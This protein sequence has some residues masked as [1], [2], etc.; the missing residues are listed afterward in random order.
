MSFIDPIATAIAEAL[1]PIIRA[2]LEAALA[3]HNTMQPAHADRGQPN[4]S[5]AE[6]ALELGA[7]ERQVR[8][9]LAAGRLRGSRAVL[10]G[11]SRVRI[12][13]QSV[14]ALLRGAP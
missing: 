7:S 6:A 11:S 1:R 2:E 14:D 13:R 3:A 4:C 9:W 8:R 5:V 10:S 12:E